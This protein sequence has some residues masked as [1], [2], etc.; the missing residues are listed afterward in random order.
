MHLKTLS[1]AL[2]SQIRL[3]SFPCCH[4]FIVFLSTTLLSTAATTPLSSHPLP[5]VELEVITVT[6]ATTGPKGFSSTQTSRHKT[7]KNTQKY[8]QIIHVHTCLLFSSQK[9]NASP[10][11]SAIM[12]SFRRHTERS[13]LREVPDSTKRN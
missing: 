4:I 6:T 13:N 8:S 10:P 5:D 3:P 12:L 7:H 11:F 9:Q 2:N 1:K